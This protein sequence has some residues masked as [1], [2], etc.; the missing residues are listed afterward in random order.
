MTGEERRQLIIA[1]LRQ[2]EKPTSASAFALEYGVSRQ[3]IVGDIALIRASGIEVR[4]TSRGY[5]LEKDNGKTGFRG[6]VVC[7]HAAEETGHELGLIIAAGSKIVDVSVAHPLYGE[8][9]GNLDLKTDEDVTNFMALITQER[10]QLLSVLTS[11]IHIHTIESK[12]ESAFLEVKKQLN[13]AGYLYES[14]EG[15]SR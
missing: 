11:G 15:S 8:L 5:V 7:Q 3:V 14:I 9:K 4:A 12:D 2:T 10:F 6:Q 1:V 13:Q